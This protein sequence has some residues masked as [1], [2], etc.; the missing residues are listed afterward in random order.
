MATVT[1]AAAVSGRE[2]TKSEFVREWL[3]L[4]RADWPVPLFDLLLIIPSVFLQEL[5]IILGQGVRNLLALLLVF[6]SL[7]CWIKSKASIFW[8]SLFEW[9]LTSFRSW[10]SRHDDDCSLSPILYSCSESVQ[11]STIFCQLLC[12]PFMLVLIVHCGVC[13]AVWPNATLRAGE[14]RS[15]EVG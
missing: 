5:N 15:V 12:S 13:N 11:W 1:I 3:W 14:G 6:P 4:T 10:I 9:S 7:S 2:I 8:S